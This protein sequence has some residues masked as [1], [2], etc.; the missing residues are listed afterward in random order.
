MNSKATSRGGTAAFFVISVLHHTLQYF[1][2]VL[3]NILNK[4]IQSYK[5]SELQSLNNYEINAPFSNSEKTFKR[6]CRMELHKQTASVPGKKKNFTCQI[7]MY[8]LCMF[9]SSGSEYQGKQKGGT[10]L[11]TLHPLSFST[12]LSPGRFHCIGFIQTAT[13]LF[14]SSPSL[15]TAI[16][17]KK[18]KK[19]CAHARTAP[20]SE[21]ALYRLEGNRRR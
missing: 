2:H 4:L 6:P 14:S 13:L 21:T 8:P 7:C 9:P 20:R 12:L 11:H 16:G 1:H 15:F 18:A 17:G 5:T 10:K 19:K 3:H